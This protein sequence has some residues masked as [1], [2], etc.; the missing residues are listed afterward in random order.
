MN[1]KSIF[2]IL[3]MS[4][5]ITTCDSNEKNIV[6]KQKS[7]C[8]KI[9]DILTDCMDLHRGAFDYV[10]TCGDISYERVSNAKTCK[11]VFDIIEE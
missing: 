10:D 2:F 6:Y 11:E 8:E 9:K 3:V 1:I 4:T 7:R 5:I